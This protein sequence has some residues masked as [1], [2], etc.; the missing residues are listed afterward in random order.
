MKII[1]LNIRGFKVKGKFGWVRSICL[2]E[3]PWVAVFQETKCKDVSDSWVHSLWGDLNCGFIQ[4]GAV[5]K[6]GGFLMVWDKNAFEV[7]G[8]TSCDFFVAIR[9]KWK[10]TGEES[11]IVNIYGPHKDHKKIIMW[12]LLDKLMGSSNS[13][14]LL[15]GDFNEVRSSS[16]RL[17]TQFHQGRADLFNDFVSRN[18]L[19]E[20]PISGRKFT[21]ISDDGLKFSKLDRVLVSDGFLQLWE[22]LSIITLDRHLSDNCPLILRDKVLDYGPRPFKVF[23]E[24]FNCV[25]VGEVIKEAWEQPI[26]GSRKDCAFRDK[27]KN[28]K[29]ALKSWSHNKFGSLDSEINA[30]KKEAMEWELKAE[31]NILSVLDRAK[32]LDCRRHWVEK[33]KVKSNMLKQKAKVKWILDGDENSKFFHATLRRKY[34][35]SNFRGLVVDGVWQEDPVLVKDTIFNHFKNQF[36]KKM[37]HGP[38]IFGGFRSF[39]LATGGLDN[40]RN[41]SPANGPSGPIVHEVNIAEQICLE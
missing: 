24:W 23:D 10:T 31:S 5:G 15:C 4:K 9:G 41:S 28:V 17:N 2:K 18:C 34:N 14:W 25:D 26:V 20:I 36:A 35:K 37:D 11:I 27:L 12:D 32:W 19:V 6:S 29:V 39:K 33:E 8:T 16:E 1:S 38:R 22:D 21:K 30:L 40:T 7:D 3:R 13:K